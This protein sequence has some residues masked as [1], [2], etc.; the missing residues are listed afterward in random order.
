MQGLGAYS[1]P[2]DGVLGPAS[3]A[4]LLACMRSRNTR[5]LTLE[6]FAASAKDLG[7]SSYALRAVVAVESGAS[8]FDRDGRPLIL[9]EPHKFSALTDGRWDKQFP[10]LSYKKWARCLTQTPAW[11][12]TS[13]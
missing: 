13:T 5:P 9:P 6:Q 1:G 10:A 11:T 2:L 8:G 4:A 3:R 7:C 12:V